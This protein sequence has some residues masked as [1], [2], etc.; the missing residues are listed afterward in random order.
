L[1]FTRKPDY[2]PLA[3]RNVFRNLV[4]TAFSQRRKKMFKQISAIFNPDKITAGMTALNI[5]KDARAE[6]LTVKQFVAMAKMLG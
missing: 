5:S 1:K 4:R 3:E 6:E 2:L